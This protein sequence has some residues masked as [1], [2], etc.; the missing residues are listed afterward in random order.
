M[1][2]LHSAIVVIS[3][4]NI[5]ILRDRRKKVMKT[6]QR[7]HMTNASWERLYHLVSQNNTF[8]RIWLSNTTEQFTSHIGPKLM[9]KSSNDVLSIVNTHLLKKDTT[10][11]YA[12]EFQGLAEI[13]QYL[14]AMDHL[15]TKSY[16]SLCDYL[17]KWH[18]QQTSVEE[19]WQ[20]ARMNI[21]LNQTV[22]DLASRLKIAKGP[23]YVRF[24]QLV[25][26]E[27]VVILKKRYEKSLW[28]Q[29]RNW[30]IL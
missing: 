19:S 18:W 16:D 10:A 1:L 9:N 17:W 26:D 2:L 12:S 5:D 23:A 24:C 28:L 14:V 30:G 4:S 7:S 22:I 6:Y 21:G 25:G 8:Q 27:C 29:D 13:A 15:G 20:Y 11:E 3:F